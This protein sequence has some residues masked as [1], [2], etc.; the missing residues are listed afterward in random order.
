[1]RN[2]VRETHLRPGRAQFA[3]VLFDVERGAAVGALH[4]E[5]GFQQGHLTSKRGF[6]TLLRIQQGFQRCP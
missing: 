6:N 2:T 4:L 1:V 3:L 5:V